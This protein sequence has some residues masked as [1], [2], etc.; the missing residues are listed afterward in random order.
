MV[1][2]EPGLQ[3][4][5]LRTEAFGG[6]GKGYAG[7]ESERGPQQQGAAWRVSRPHV[8]L[9]HFLGDSH[10]ELWVFQQF[11]HLWGGSSHVSSRKCRD[12]TCRS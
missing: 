1:P 3:C 10:W 9:C 2:S 7:P 8:L 11:S 4:E 5:T 6:G 12:F